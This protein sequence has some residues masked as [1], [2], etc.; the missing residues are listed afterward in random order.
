MS[1][2]SPVR[3]VSSG[4]LWA[5]RI[6]SGL[7]VL[8]LLFDSTV[9]LIKASSAVQGTLQLGYPESTVV[10]IGAVLLLSLVL[11]VIPRTSILGRNS[12]DWLPGRC[13]GKHGAYRQSMVA[14]SHTG[15]SAGVGGSL[16]SRRTV[17]R[18]HSPS[19]FV[20]E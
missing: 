15:W 3:P 13:D 12:V 20:V 2:T 4:M 7:L 9:K 14:I 1:S 5:G 18:T 11:Y 6:I 8:F 16:F 10:P 19:P 17:A